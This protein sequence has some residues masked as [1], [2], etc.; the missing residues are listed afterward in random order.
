MSSTPRRPARAEV[1]G[2]LLRPPKLRAAVEAFYEPGHSAVLADERAKD[3]SELEHLEDDAIDEAVRRQI[4]LGLDVVT[5]GEFR[6]W[7]FLNSFYDAVEGIRTDNVVSF[8]NA[9]GEDVPLSVHEVVD[10]LRPIDSP[11][12]REAAYLAG[13]TDGYPFKVTFPAASIFGHPSR[14]SSGSPTSRTGA[15]RSSSITRSR[16]SVG[17]SRLPSPPARRTSSSTS[18]CIRTWSIRP[19]PSDSCR[20][21][22]ISER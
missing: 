16:S 1:V 9:R 6:R 8:H 17:W 3:R 2:S 19:G 20:R 13:E 18:P 7:M 12:A 4:D 22:A 10:R 11:A 5:D 14:G 21:A 15:C